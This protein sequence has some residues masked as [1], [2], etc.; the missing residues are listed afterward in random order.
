MSSAQ[1][2]GG[3]RRGG[4]RIPH[5]ELVQSLAS[6]MVAQLLPLVMDVLK[7]E[8]EELRRRMRA[9]S[10]P[11]DG[12]EDIANLNIIAGQITA[13]ERRWREKFGEALQRW[14]DPPAQVSRGAVG[15]V[16]DEE[17]QAQLIGQPV[18]EALERRHG[19]MLDTIEKRLWSLAA[20]M[21]GQVR[22]DNPF[23]PRHVVESFLHTFTASDCGPRLRDALLRHCERLAGQRL[24]EAYDWCNRQLAES[25]LALASVSD[26]A[27]LAATTV[28]ARGVADVA[29]LDVWG[30]DNALAP[31]QAS[32]R[33]AREG[34]EPRRDVLRGDALRH[35]ARSRRDAAGARA[36][37]VRD[38]R[39]EE[40][41][42]VM[43]LLQGESAP[44]EGTDD[45]YSQAMRAGLSRVDRK[46][47]V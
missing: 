22:P 39:E 4:A 11:D 14:P 34:G 28:G 30:A 27:T 8:L 15:L 29:K 25:G 41:L 3:T 6:G 26:Y 35:A 17:L 37:G 7:A 31:A 1:S 13:Y 36:D 23:S 18:I 12:P 9:D 21:G 44:L 42:A 45:G 24:G 47:V 46:S 16:S 10:P 20:A 19:D 5:A 33:V 2:S 43:S 40:I 38:M 32:W